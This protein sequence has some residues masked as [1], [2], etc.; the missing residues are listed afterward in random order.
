MLK[1]LKSAKK[2]VLVFITVIVAVAFLVS[3]LSSVVFALFYDEHPLAYLVS[4]CAFLA[5]FGF[6]SFILVTASFASSDV[7]VKMN[8]TFDRKNIRFVDI[9]H[10]P[11]SV[12]A[13]VT[14][15]HLDVAQQQYL[16][17]CAQILKFGGSDLSKFL[18]DVVQMVLLSN[19]LGRG[20]NSLPKDFRREIALENLPE[21]IKENKLLVRH[22]GKEPVISVMDKYKVSAINPRKNFFILE[23]PYGSISFTWFNSMI[24]TSYNSG[25]Y[26]ESLEDVDPESCCDFY[27]T[28]TM[29]SKIGLLRLLS[30]KTQVFAN[31]G[32]SIADVL[33]EWDWKRA[34]SNLPMLMLGR[35]LKA[36][37]KKT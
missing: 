28:V 15:N 36:V 3:S 14:F 23:G 2:E 32:S 33:Q 22:L 16:G 25:A 17:A 10:C 35:I 7:T 29:K 21:C 37:V 4:V 31:W 18:D 11:S 26:L 13:R 24:Q 20:S 6:I 30:S 19:I 27:S 5:V 12:N 1:N 8:F 34:Q 9:P